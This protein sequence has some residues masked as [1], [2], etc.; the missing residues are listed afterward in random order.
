MRAGEVVIAVFYGIHCVIVLLLPS[1]SCAFAGEIDEWPGD[2]G[3]VADPDPH[4]AC[5]AKKGADVR[6]HLAPRPVA[7][8]GDLRVIR[9]TTFVVA[10]VTKDGDFRDCDTELA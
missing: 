1:E 5:S 2:G 6:E 10:L 4:V 3:V 7:D 8:S 9:D